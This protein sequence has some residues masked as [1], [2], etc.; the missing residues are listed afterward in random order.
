[1]LA[2]AAGRPRTAER[3]SNPNA[4]LI[5]ISA[6]IALVAIVMSVKMDLPRRVLDPPTI[7]DLIRPPP[8][9]PPHITPPARP[10]EPRQIEATAPQTYVPTP[11]VSIS[12]ANP[13]PTLP[14]IGDLIPSTAVPPRIEPQPHAV[15]APTIPRLLTPPAEIRPPYPQSKLLTGEEATLTLRLDIDEQGHVVSV[16]PV[17][18][19]DAVFLDAARRYLIAHWRYQPATRD[20]RPVAS[21]LTVTLRFEL[22]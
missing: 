7:I 3:Q 22:D 1:M 9:P 15:V 12:T 20:G 14:N 8:P 6:H 2:Y 18:R 17:G 21:N 4:L 16:E 5:I 10:V 19:A 11:P 13:T